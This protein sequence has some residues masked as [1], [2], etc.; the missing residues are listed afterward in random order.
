MRVAFGLFQH[1]ANSFC[2][3]PTNLA[4][5][6]RHYYKAGAE[7]L[8]TTRG[9]ATEDAGALAV[10]CS[11]PDIE[12][13]P[14]LGVKAGSGAAIERDTY[15]SLRDDLLRRLEAAMP[16]DGLLLV[17]HGAMMAEGED[18]ASGDILAAA[19]QLLGEGMPI[20]VSLDLHANVTCRMAKMATALVG[21][22]TAPHIDL[23]ETGQ[24][25]AEILVDTLHGKIQP[26]MALCRLPLI[27][28]AENARHT[29]GPLADIINRALELEL[30][31]EILHGGVYPVQPWLDAPD[32]GCSVVVVT[33]K[34]AARAHSYALEMGSAF[35]QRRTDFIPELVTPAAAIAKA[36]DGEA[37]TVILCDSSD[38]PS[39]GA[40]GDSSSLLHA[41]L[42]SEINAEVLT[43]VVD[44]PA[45]ERACQAGVDAEIEVDL[46][47]SLAPQY[48]QPVRFR[49][50][51][52]SL[53]NGVFRFKGQGM[54]GVTM[55]MGRTAVL[56]RGSLRVV[57]ME[58]GVTQW[59]PE[60][61][62]SLGLEP[63][64]A[65]IVQVKSPAAF[66]AAYADIADEIILLDTP[67]AASPKL[68]SLAWQRLS[69]PIYPLD[70]LE[71]TPMAE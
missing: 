35:W 22:H 28:P 44:A 62:R 16:V 29:D 32:V 69:R 9:I 5:F 48:Y 19:R 61:Y 52:K 31:G 30:R 56:E 23:Y 46:G 66:R 42:A 64:D 6:Q 13:V 2:P 37:R 43:N 55:R 10:L 45:V 1:E 20:V 47:G 3:Q 51:V 7:L 27:V 40:T 25:A 24:R 17:L 14:L 26:Q 18:D 60:L 15:Q 36:L 39:S 21:Y 11:Q 67:G 57:V 34:D 49:G 68:T 33:D 12:V 53:H 65:R 50:I 58:H 71:H 63:K 70:D 59:D 54:R 38:A 41:L 4:G 8:E